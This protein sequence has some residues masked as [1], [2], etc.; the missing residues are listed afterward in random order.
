LSR[1]R[2]NQML[3]GLGAQKNLS[4]VL[5]DA[6]ELNESFLAREQRIVVAANWS[7]LVCDFAQRRLNSVLLFAIQK[8][9][10]ASV[11]LPASLLS[12]TAASLR[13]TGVASLPSSHRRRR[14]RRLTA[15]CAS[16]LP[17]PPRCRRR[18]RRHLI[19]AGLPSASPPPPPPPHRFRRLTASILHCCRHLTAVT[20]SPPSPA[21]AAAAVSLSLLRLR[22]AATAVLPL[23]HRRRRRRRRRRGTRSWALANREEEVGQRGDRY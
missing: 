1:R 16:P 21:A 2:F 12:H 22:L 6:K 10:A 18:R 8:R 23:P 19:V 5:T 3:F 9:L 11:V 15:T 4:I 7:S 13:L 17:L 20:S 14:R